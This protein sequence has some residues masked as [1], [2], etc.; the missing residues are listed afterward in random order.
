M[1]DYAIRSAEGYEPDKDENILS[2][3]FKQYESVIVQSLITSFGLDFLVTDRHGG[4]VDTIHNVRQIGSD[5]ELQ[6]KNAANKAAYDNRG[7][8]NSSE[9]HSDSRYISKNREVRKKAESCTT[10]IPG[11]K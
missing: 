2:S 4:D 6:Y 8:Y 9:Y 7:E 1:S 10:P 11:K 3:I 5:P